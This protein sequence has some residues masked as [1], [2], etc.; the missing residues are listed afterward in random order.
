MKTYVR[1]QQGQVLT[2]NLW[3]AGTT[4]RAILE[5]RPR[6]ELKRALLSRPAAATHY[7]QR[8]RKVSTNKGGDLRVDTNAPSSARLVGF[9]PR[10]HTT[11]KRAL[12]SRAAAANHYLQ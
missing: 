3:V 12:L 2:C 7:L 8:K 11:L 9:C 10:S 4:P 6:T 5:A 1:D